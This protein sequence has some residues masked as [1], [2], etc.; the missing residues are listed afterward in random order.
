M[1]KNQDLNNWATGW[2]DWNLCLNMGGGP[3][4]Q[5]NYVDAAIIVNAAADEFYK[6]PMY[7][8]LGHF[9]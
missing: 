6:N 5:N 9:R 8:A 3:N 2:V 1:K 7:Y 4:W